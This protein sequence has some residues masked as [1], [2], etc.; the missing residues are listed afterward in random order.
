[1]PR[2]F[3]ALIAAQFFS[4]LADN[5]LLLL[6]IAVL[7]AQNQDAFWIPVIK[8]MFTLSYV[9]AGPWAGAWSDN[10]SKHKVMMQANGIKFIACAFL[11]FGA[12]P[13]LA[14]TITGLGAAFYAPA[15][16]GLVTELVPNEQLVRANAW[17]EVSVVC[18]ALLGVM[19]GGALVADRWLDSSFYKFI[20]QSLPVNQLFDASLLFVLSLYLM[21]ALINLKIRASGHQYARTAWSF[22]SVWNNFVKDQIKLWRD[23]LGNI[24]LSVTTL[25]WGVGASMQ[26]LVLAWGQAMLDLNLTQSAYL[27]AGTALG[28][29]AGAVLASQ[30]VSLKNAPHVLFV[31][32]L[33][34]LFLPLMT[35][36][37]DWLW[38]LALTFSLGVLGGFFV[39]PMNAMLQARGV[40]LLSAGRSISVQNTCENSSVLVLLAI[41]SALVF[42]HIPVSGLVWALSAL[43]VTGMCFTTWRYKRMR[44]NKLL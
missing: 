17:I 21:A 3:Y 1:M 25:F 14:F 33:L 11:L 38:A 2:G 22:D 30:M 4:A 9:L 8:L 42:M 32:I 34:G 31:G 28:V 12:N 36:I 20:S 39:V 41:Y 7:Q 26:L 23:P 29:I 10:H 37:N 40:Q 19:L 16:Y 27:Q 15:K 18:S 24:S 13:I 44:N 43:I 5:A 6:V 35:I